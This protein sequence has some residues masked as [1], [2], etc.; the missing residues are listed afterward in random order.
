MKQYFALLFSII[1]PGV[2]F[3]CSC[4][5]ESFSVKHIVESNIVFRGKV[6]LT[7]EVNNSIV[8]TFRIQEMIKGSHP[9][10]RIEIISPSLGPAC[11]IKIVENQEIYYLHTW[12][13]IINCPLISVS[14]ISTSIKPIKS[15]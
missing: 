12:T 5:P 2:V 8:Y 4:D 14:K 13:R 6:I 3:S 11:A 9:T 7:E 1:I 10:K 15:I